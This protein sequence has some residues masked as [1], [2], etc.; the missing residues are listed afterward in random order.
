MATASPS[1]E[2]IQRE[3]RQVRAELRGDMQQ[4]VEQA[5]GLSDWQAYV[6]AYPWA[7]MGAAAVVGY[8]LVPARPVIIRPDAKEMMELAKANRLEFEPIAKSKN[9][10]PGI[11]GSIL[12]YAGSTLLQLGIAAVTQQLSQF[13][14]SLLN[15][16]APGNRGAAGD[17]WRKL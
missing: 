7:A 10:R 8:L 17:S 1:A 13:Q 5:N 4:I 6:R 16:S 9:S 15:P 3:M 11:M 14:N 2:E 12:N